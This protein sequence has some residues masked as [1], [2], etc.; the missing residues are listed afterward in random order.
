MISVQNR[1]LSAFRMQIKI[2]ISIKFISRQI[3]INIQKNLL[4]SKFIF[5]FEGKQM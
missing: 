5:T 1:A 2:S 4:N 3:F